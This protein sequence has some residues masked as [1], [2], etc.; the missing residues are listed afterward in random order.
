MAVE[1]HLKKPMYKDII[2]FWQCVFPPRLDEQ[3]VIEI[4]NVLND[5]EYRVFQSMYRIDQIHG[6]EVYLAMLKY[7]SGHNIP[8]ADKLKKAILLHD[9]GKNHLKITVFDR[10]VVGVL[11]KFPSGMRQKFFSISI[12]AF[13]KSAYEKNNQH[14][15]AG[16]QILEENNIDPQIV[17]LVRY[18]HDREACYG[19]L[20]DEGR[21]IYSIDNYF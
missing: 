2:R 15:E 19:D 10:V 9:V 6:H 17:Q 5:N 21:L 20:G 14:P 12:C 13:L 4:K 3:A 11:N 8:I 18:H 7:A 1:I 16:A